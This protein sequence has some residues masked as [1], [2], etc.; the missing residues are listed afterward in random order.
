MQP[1]DADNLERAKL[2][3]L[4]EFA[5][6]AGHE[7]NNPLAVIAGRRNSLLRG[8]VIPNV[9]A[10]WRSFTSPG[11]AHP[12]DDRR[13]DA[14]CPT[15][16][17]DPPAGDAGDRRGGRRRIDGEGRVVLGV[18][19]VKSADA[20]D[21]ADR[22]PGTVRASLRAVIDNGP[23]AGTTAASRM[24]MHDHPVHR[25]RRWHGHS[26]SRAAAP[27]H[28]FDSGQKRP[29]PGVG[30]SKAWRFVTDHAAHH[31]RRDKARTGRVHDPRAREPRLI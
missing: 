18:A 8:D 9:A 25:R 31:G 27:L 2:E 10:I 17:A 19:L 29:R 6:G 30:L 7:I 15:A 11:H 24:Q 21:A 1:D 4:A 20:T 12:R 28:P 14:L 22:D 13:P 23:T 5:A 3:S 26:G 16:G